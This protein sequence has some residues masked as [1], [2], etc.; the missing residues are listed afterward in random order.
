MKKAA[1]ANKTNARG[2]ERPEA[3]LG[4]V[5]DVAAPVEDVVFDPVELDPVELVFDAE[6][7]L[8]PVVVAEEDEE[9][10]VDVVEEPDEEDPVEEEPVEV[11]DAADEVLL[12][13]PISWNCGL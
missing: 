3:E 10:P 11:E 8:E 7:V 4:A 9:E 6:D 1:R 2:E 13:P 5:V 12:A